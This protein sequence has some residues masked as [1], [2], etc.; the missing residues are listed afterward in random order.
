MLKS[1]RCQA[2]QNGL[3]LSKSAVQRDIPISCKHRSS[4]LCNSLSEQAECHHAVISCLTSL[5]CKPLRGCSAR[6][7]LIFVI[8]LSVPENIFPNGGLNSAFIQIRT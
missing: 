1:L 7:N 3:A 5:Q 6:L 2:I 4:R 8:A